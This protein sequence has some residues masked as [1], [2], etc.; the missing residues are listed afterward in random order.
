MNSKGICIHHKTV[1]NNYTNVQKRCQVCDL[2]VQWNGLRC[3]CC[4]VN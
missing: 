2:F 3:P 4:D 1:S